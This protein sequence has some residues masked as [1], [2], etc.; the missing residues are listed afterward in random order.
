MDL[1]KGLYR[2]T[3]WVNVSTGRLGADYNALLCGRIAGQ[4]GLFLHTAQNTG[5]SGT[6]AAPAD[7]KG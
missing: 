4:G 2:F 3:T 1:V 5:D 6:Q 7:R